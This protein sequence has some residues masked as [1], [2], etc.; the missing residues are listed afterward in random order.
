MCMESYRQIVD[1][2]ICD[3]CKIEFSLESK[4][5]KDKQ[6]FCPVCKIELKSWQK[7]WEAQ[8]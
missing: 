6:V 2:F 3:N 8:R 7:E 1:L 4:L 5:I